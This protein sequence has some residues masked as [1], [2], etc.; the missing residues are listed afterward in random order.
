MSSTCSGFP[1][2]YWIHVNNVVSNLREARS[3]LIPLQ[4]LNPC[5]Y[6]VGMP[7]V[8]STEPNSCSLSIL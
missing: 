5:R 8:I 1:S 7:V 4:V 6:T 3:Q 2:W